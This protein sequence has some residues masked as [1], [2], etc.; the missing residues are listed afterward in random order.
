MTKR[1]TFKFDLGNSNNGP[2]GL[3]ANIRAVSP[4]AALTRLRKLL[5]GAWDTD[6]LTF[7]RPDGLDTADEYLVV[8]FNAANITTADI[9]GVVDEDG[10]LLPVSGGGTEREIRGRSATTGEVLVQP[11]EHNTIIA[12]ADGR[13]EY[14][15]WGPPQM[16]SWVIARVPTDGG[17]G[18]YLRGHAADG[19]T[20]VRIARRLAEANLHDVAVVPAESALDGNSAAP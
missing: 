20:A 3:V 7:L 9:L 16:A 6:Q 15:V 8:Y 5:P 4:E 19:P 18:K 10:E 1:R 12:S 17:R 11:P 13:Y 2:V 14:K